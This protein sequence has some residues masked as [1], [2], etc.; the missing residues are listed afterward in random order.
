MKCTGWLYIQV[1]ISI[2]SYYYAAYEVEFTYLSLLANP[3]LAAARY[4]NFRDPKLI[5]G[6]EVEPRG[7]WRAEP[8][9]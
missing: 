1:S 4:E 8:W 2:V 9:K 7:D 5:F 6:A 3:H